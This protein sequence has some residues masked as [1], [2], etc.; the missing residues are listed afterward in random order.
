MDAFPLEHGSF[1][2]E[3]GLPSHQD[4]YSLYHTHVYAVSLAYVQ[5]S[6]QFT[7]DF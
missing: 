1:L 2:Q 5:F 3:G 4:T 6:I 7:Y